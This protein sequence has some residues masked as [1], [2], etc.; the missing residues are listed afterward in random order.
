LDI[1]G[2]M[3]VVME[4]RTEV[5]K[6]IFALQY[7]LIRRIG[8]CDWSQDFATLHHCRDNENKIPRH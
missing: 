8:I 3:A 2:F 6:E 4:N 1:Y 7:R 5:E